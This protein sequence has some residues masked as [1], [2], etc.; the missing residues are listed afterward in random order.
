M[1][2]PAHLTV[3][4]LPLENKQQ[5]EQTINHHI[6][7]C[8]E[9]NAKNLATQWNNVL[10]YMWSKDD[11]HYMP[12]FKRLTKILD[13]HRDESLETAIPELANLL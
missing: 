13:Q 10:N 4:A 3:S 1:V 7:W 6:A 11:S 2:G 8:K 5:L 9:H 12:E